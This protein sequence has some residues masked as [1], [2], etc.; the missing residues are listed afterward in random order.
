MSKQE[1]Y[2]Q[3]GLERLESGAGL[4]AS[5]KE[6][7]GEEREL[8]KLASRMRS[9]EWPEGDPQVVN[10][11]RKQL[12]DI[13]IKEMRME[14]KQT[15]RFNPFRDWRILVPFS[16][17]MALLLVC[18]LPLALVHRYAQQANVRPVL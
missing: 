14:A 4:E 13:Y 16:F 9:T 12:G 18:G 11:Q 10:T 8:L 2:L 6:L 15:P 7:P 17:G 1:D 5:Q 3:D